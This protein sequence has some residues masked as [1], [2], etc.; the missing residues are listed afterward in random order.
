MV[1]RFK[2]YKL[3]CYTCQ[4]YGN[5]QFPGIG[6]HQRVTQRLHNTIF[7]RHSEGVSQKALSEHF[8][9]GKA[10]IERWYHLEYQLAYKE[11]ETRSCPTVLGIDEHFFNRKIGFAT[12]LCDLRKHKVFDIVKGH[13]ANT[14]SGYLKQLPRRERVKVICIDL[15]S[16]YK[17]LI[18]DYFPNAKLVADRFHVIRLINQQCLQTFQRLDNKM[19]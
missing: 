16:R 12:T 19:K 17:R 13:C 9:M 14:L 15:C 11:V 1:L 8:K 18:Q 10:T 5:Q 2:A 3:Y 7:H 6:K 4:R